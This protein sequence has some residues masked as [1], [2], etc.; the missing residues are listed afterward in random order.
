MGQSDISSNAA[1]GPDS[2]RILYVDKDQGFAMLAKFMLECMGHKVSL[3]A[4]PEEAIDALA[5]SPG[6]WEMV[7][8]D[9]R[10]EGMSGLE[11]VKTVQGMYPDLPCG[12]VS[13]Y[14]G[15]ETEKAAQAAG[16]H[17]VLVKPVAL[18]EFYTL[19]ERVSGQVGSATERV[20]QPGADQSA[21]A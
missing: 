14:C 11:V 2:R 5:C 12:V 1:H 9:F 21:R 13:A 6:G 19:L 15:R 4:N 16:M 8:A 20:V 10:L 3:F 7:I 18:E 17:P